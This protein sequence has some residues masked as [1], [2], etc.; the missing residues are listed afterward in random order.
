MKVWMSLTLHH[1]GLINCSTLYMRVRSNFSFSHKQVC[2]INVTF[3]KKKMAIH[4]Q[5]VNNLHQRT[6]VKFLSAIVLSD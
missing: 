4:Q 1:N 3:K 5:D 6:K 2:E